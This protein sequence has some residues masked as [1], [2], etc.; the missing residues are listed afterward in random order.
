MTIR[1]ALKSVLEWGLARR[2]YRIVGPGKRYGIDAFADIETLCQAMGDSVRVVF[3]VGAND[4][5]TAR[6]SLEAFPV[7]EVHSFEPQPDVFAA[8]RDAFAGEPRVHAVN[9]ALAD[10]AGDATLFQFEYGSVLGSL[11]PNAQNIVG[12]AHRE[13]ATQV[14]A[15]TTLD[16]YSESNGVQTV[17]VLKIDTEGFELQ[18]LQ[19]SRGML[20]RGRIKY[21]Y[22]E[23]NDLQPLPGTFGG[24][25]LPIDDLLR[26]YGFRFIA[27]YV[28]WVRTDGS[29]FVISNALFALAPAARPPRVD[30][31]PYAASNK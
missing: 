1:G 4:G 3:D 21:V 16:H 28:D 13:V 23:F 15:C 18:V 26:P 14:V 31:S 25:L 5:A 27:T 9:T 19:G 22:V 17:D 12:N 6:R 10:K 29:M 30:A 7:A 2:G 20:S 24:A 8:L 11:V